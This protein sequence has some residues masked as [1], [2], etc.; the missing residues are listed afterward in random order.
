MSLP[1]LI[2]ARHQYKLL[3]APKDMS[4][5]RGVWIYGSPGVGKS[6]R[7]RTVIPQEDLFLKSM[8]KWWDGYEGQPNVLLDDFDK[9]GKVLGHYLKIWSDKWACTGEVKGSTVPL[10]Y[11]KFFITSNYHPDDIWPFNEDE[12]LNKAICRRFRIIHVITYD[13]DVKLFV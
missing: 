9:N 2:K 10:N 8:N 13:Q 6:H 4:E 7:V 5:V 1:G 11:Q 12:E 3:E